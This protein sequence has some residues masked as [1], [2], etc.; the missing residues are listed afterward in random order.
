MS[1]VGHRLSTCTCVDLCLGTVTLPRDIHIPTRQ[2]C[3]YKPRILTGD[4]NTGRLTRDLWARV[5]FGSCIVRMLI[6]QYCFEDLDLFYDLLDY[7]FWSY[8]ELFDE[9]IWLFDFAVG[10]LEFEVRLRQLFVDSQAHV[11]VLVQSGFVYLMIPVCDFDVLL[12]VKF[13]RLEWREF[14]LS[15]LEWRQSDSGLSLLPYVFV[16]VVHSTCSISQ[17]NC[18]ADDGIS[19]LIIV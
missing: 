2:R 19:D 4:R 12:T 3:L 14:V 10:L 11:C 9:F 13:Q 17:V 1:D 15:T 16:I 7:W 6:L 18:D 8:V 5:M